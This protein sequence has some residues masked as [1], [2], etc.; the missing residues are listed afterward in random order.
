MRFGLILLLLGA[1]H[2]ASHAQSIGDQERRLAALPAATQ[3]EPALTPTWETQKSARTYVLT[4]PPPRGQIVD[5]HGS[6]LAQNRVSYN[7]ALKFPTPLNYNET[8]LRSFVDI[9][10]RN[11]EKLL[12]RQFQIDWRD[13]LQ[14]YKN[15]GIL[16]YEI[17]RD[18]IPSE[19]ELL[20]KNPIAGV[21]LNAVYLRFYP[22][23]ELAGHI[24][25][26]AGRSGSTPSGPVNNNDPIFPEAEGREGLEKTFDTQLTGEPGQYNITLDAKGKIASERVSIPPQPGFNVVTTLDEGIQRRCEEILSKSARRGALVVINPNNGDILAMAS[27][28]VFNPNKFIPG[29]STADFKTLQD[30]PNIPLLPRAF[31]SAYPPGSVFKV[32]VGLAALESHTIDIDDEFN[33]PPSF[34][35]GSLTFRN[36]KRTDAGMLNFRQA[37]TQSCNTWFY[38]VGIKTRSGPIIDWATRLGFGSKTGIPLASEV[39]GR[40]P[41]DEYMQAAYGRK[42]LDGDI[43]N[44]A[45]GQGDI[46]I[47]P[48]Q[49]AQAMATIGNG[50]TFF[51]TRL[52]QQVQSID[53][54]IVNAYEV[55]AKDKLL[56]EPAILENL[57]R[58]M[59]DVVS[60]GNGTAGR[61]GVDGVDVAGKTGTAQWGPKR[62]ERTA[63][64][65]A[66]FAPAEAPRYAYAALYEGAPNDGDVHGGTNAAPMIGKLLKELFKEKEAKAVPAEESDEA[67]AEAEA[68]PAEAGD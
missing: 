9:Q 58:A 39:A 5:R 6:P 3:E 51:Q 35:L 20:Q 21:V 19:I 34:S 4:I 43:A 8:Q 30:D 7:L 16:P 40:I 60:A 42:L 46:L 29:I 62:N 54:R 56:I 12:S 61:A 26:Y 59:V 28:P 52:V 53:D 27:W 31:R 25:G 1:V 67:P 23:A 57:K 32:P 10:L 36:W 15:R 33:C 13:L 44:M 17:A 64:W 22:N 66:G 14:Y 24:V 41:T 18:L 55:R 49:M 63:A 2:S 48:L 50:G 45:I 37:L 38:Q 68:V 11:L 65:F 47:S